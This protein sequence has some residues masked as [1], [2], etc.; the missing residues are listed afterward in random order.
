MQN[1]ERERNRTGKKGWERGNVKEG[2]RGGVIEN[3]KICDKIG[4]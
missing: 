1:M 4:R 2:E 3:Q